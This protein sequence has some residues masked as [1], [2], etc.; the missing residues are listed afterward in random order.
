MRIGI[1]GG[2]FDPIHNGHL[3]VAEEARDRFKLDR[4]LFVP[5]RI[6]PHKPDMRISSGEHRIQM[7]R[8]A[9]QDHPVFEV[10]DIEL[11]R[12]GPSYTVDT[13][14]QLQS[15]GELY[16]LIGYDSF[17]SIDTWCA[18]EEIFSLCRIVVASR[19][20]SQPV[21]P[22]NLT[23]FLR[24]F[25]PAGIARYDPQD[26]PG[27]RTDDPNWRICF[28]CIP[29]MNISSSEIRRRVSNHA[30]IRYLV[31]AAVARYILRECLYSGQTV[32]PE[33]ISENT[34]D[35]R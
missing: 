18:Y 10:S 20:G 14:K 4:V 29:G 25:F 32:Q 7:V 2:T 26:D 15:T 31:P 34:G 22:E 12:K 6:P 17:L 21:Q 28:L 35:K 1:L 16:L 27:N 9:V 3:I 11:V 5:A 23:P 24:N 33:D 19:P 30:S 8:L 13:L